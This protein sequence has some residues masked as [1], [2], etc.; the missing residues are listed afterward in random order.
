MPATLRFGEVVYLVYEATLSPDRWPA[1]LDA[2][3]G[4]ST[5]PAP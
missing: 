3:A 5:Q 1:A 2:V 4:L